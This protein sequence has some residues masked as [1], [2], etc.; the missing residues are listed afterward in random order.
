MRKSVLTIAALM[1]VSA[2]AFASDLCTP[3]AQSEWMTKEAMTAKATAMGYE[4][5]GVKIEDGCWEV[6]G[7]KDG[8][9]VEVYFDTVSGE[10]VH[11]K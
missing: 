8:K 7:K 5:K 3:H 4:V 6:K 11:S 9:R 10:Q 1:L 2:P